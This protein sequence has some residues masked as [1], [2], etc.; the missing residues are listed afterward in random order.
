MRYFPIYTL[1]TFVVLLYHS[2]KGAQS[3][4]TPWQS[5]DEYVKAHKADLLL[6]YSVGTGIFFLVWQNPALLGWV[7]GKFGYDLPFAF[8]MNGV[9]AWF[10]GLGS[11]TL[12]D[13]FLSVMAKIGQT[14]RG[15]VGS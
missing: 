6:R 5:L 15:K 3:Q 11:D 8:K 1:G 7:G 2:L 14:I 9:N 13:I 4:W 10:F 12:A